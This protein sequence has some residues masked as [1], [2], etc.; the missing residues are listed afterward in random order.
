MAHHQPWKQKYEH[1]IATEYEPTTNPSVV[2]QKFQQMADE[3]RA[4]IPSEG[5]PKDG[6]MFNVHMTQLHRDLQNAADSFMRASD[7]WYG[8]PKTAEITDVPMQ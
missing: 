2:L 1:F 3:C 6:Y 8:M 4:S 5:A 7:A